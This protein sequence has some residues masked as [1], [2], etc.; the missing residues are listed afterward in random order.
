METISKKEYKK[1]LQDPIFLMWLRM[2]YCPVKW[3]HA[4]RLESLFEETPAELLNRPCAQILIRRHLGISNLDWSFFNVPL[5]KLL[6]ASPEALKRIMLMMGYLCLDMKL[7]HI[8]DRATRHDLFARLSQNTLRNLEDLSPFLLRSR[9]SV[10]DQV[11]SKVDMPSISRSKS[12]VCIEVGEVIFF[13]TL[14]YMISHFYRLPDTNFLEKWK[15]LYRLRFPEQESHELVDEWQLNPLIDS[16]TCLLTSKL[17]KHLEPECT[18]L[19][20]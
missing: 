6:F 10:F 12:E 11:K 8:I 20:K 3:V 18:A 17:V 13:N 9:P 14:L 15:T 7:D 19:L 1:E 16:Q 2:T 4:S 5:T